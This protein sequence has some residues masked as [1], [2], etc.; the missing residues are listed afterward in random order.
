MRFRSSVVRIEDLT[1]LARD[2]SLAVFFWS[3]QPS[4]LGCSWR[5]GNVARGLRR[6]GASRLASVRQG[7]EHVAN[8]SPTLD[9]WREGRVNDGAHDLGFEDLSCQSHRRA[10]VGYTR[11][12]S[13]CIRKGVDDRSQDV[14]HDYSRHI[15][16]RESVV[17]AWHLKVEYTNPS[18]P[19]VGYALLKSLDDGQQSKLSMGVAALEALQDRLEVL[20]R[21]GIFVGLQQIGHRQE[22]HDSS[23]A[24]QCSP[25]ASDAPVVTLDEQPAIIGQEVDVGRGGHLVVIATWLKS[26]VAQDRLASGSPPHE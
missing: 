11:T 26:A 12:R 21:K 3:I 10:Y 18:V 16:Q 2:L 25:K 14:A 22:Q 23:D 5:R 8:R 4:A 13:H 6:V 20:V 15:W 1:S 19:G 7:S 17:G 9:E 24:P